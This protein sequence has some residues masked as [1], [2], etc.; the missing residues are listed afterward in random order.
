ME[1]FRID[2]DSLKMRKLVLLFFW[3][4]NFCSG[5]LCSIWQAGGWFCQGDGTLCMKM[6][7]LEK[8][9]VLGAQKELEGRSQHNSH[10]SKLFH[11]VESSGASPGSIG[12]D[13]LA[14]GTFFCIICHVHTLYFADPLYSRDSLKW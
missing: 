12:S 10:R 8:M 11:R 6:F 7:Q 5:R 14:H 3:S 9:L 13:F 2:S 1:R 4:Q